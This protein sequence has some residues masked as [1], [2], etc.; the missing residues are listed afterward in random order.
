MA[1]RF[2]SVK[3]D[4]FTSDGQNLV[5]EFLSSY[6]KSFVKG[7]TSSKLAG[8]ALG[9]AVLSEVELPI[10]A[11][12][13]FLSTAAS[14][15]TTEKVQTH[16]EIGSVAMYKNGY[17]PVTPEEEAMLA[18]SQ[19]DDSFEPLA[20]VPRYDICIIRNE[21]ADGRYEVFDLA[22]QDTKKVSVNDLRPEKDDNLSRF[23]VFTKLKKKFTDYVAPKVMNTLKYHIGDFVSM[24]GSEGISDFS[25]IIQK[26][27]NDEVIIKAGSQLKHV[28]RKDWPKLLSK[29]DQFN[30]QHTVNGNSDLHVNQIMLYKQGKI[31]RPCV[32]VQTN[33]KLKIRAFHVQQVFQCEPTDL[34]KPSDEYNTKLYA[35][36]EYRKFI[37]M[38]KTTPF[39]QSE[40]MKIVEDDKSLLALPNPNE[41]YNLFHSKETPK[42]ALTMEDAEQHEFSEV[43]PAS[44]ETR[45]YATMPPLAEGTTKGFIRPQREETPTQGDRYGKAYKQPPTMRGRVWDN[46]KGEYVVKEAT[47]SKD[48]NSMMYL[49]AAIILVGG[50][51][52]MNK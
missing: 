48:D 10:A 47:K 21:L 45:R 39:D 9:T 42:M 2:N 6:A 11:V 44:I 25:G 27:T 18:M 28:L 12:G 14:L 23:D 20:M 4:K 8:S 1:E 50:I 33:P 49:G 16:Y 5:T 13:A 35:T 40:R 3:F 19:V 29:V 41:F 31:L 24:S 37:D 52:F 17:Y 34:V 30:L 26:I 51:F 22:Q 36:P 38:V 15:F 46:E 7:F 32:I 43:I